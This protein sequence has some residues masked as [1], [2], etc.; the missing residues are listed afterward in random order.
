MDKLKINLE[1]VRT[2]L[3]SKNEV[4]IKSLSRESTLGYLFTSGIISYYAQYINQTKIMAQQFKVRHIT[5]PTVGTFGY[6]SYKR[7][8]F[9]LNRGVEE[10][11]MYMNT[12]IVNVILDKER[13]Y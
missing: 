1:N 12:Y 4:Q 2:I 7:T 10:H 5:I 9:G 6:E 11:G 3:E 8:L 13:E